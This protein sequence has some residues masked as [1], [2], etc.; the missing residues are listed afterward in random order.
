MLKRVFMI[1]V[2]I[3]FALCSICTF[4]SCKAETKNDLSGKTIGF[5]QY[6]TRSSFYNI[7]QQTIQ[8]ECD[9]NDIRLIV[10]DSD[11]SISEQISNISYFIDI[12]VDAIIINPVDNNALSGIIGKAREEGIFVIIVDNILD[13]SIEVDVSIMADNY[14]N[15]MLAGAWLAE[16]MGNEKIK[17]LY[18]S[19][20][21]DSIVSE[22][23]RSGLINGMSEYWLDNAERVDIEIT[24]RKQSDWTA[25]GTYTA[26]T[27][28]DK[29]YLDYNCIVSEAQI[30]ALT[31][32][33][34]LKHN[35]Q[36]ERVRYI[37]CAVCDAFSADAVEL[38]TSGKM[39]SGYQ[40]P[41]LFGKEAVN[42]AVK[43]WRNEPIEDVIKQPTILIE[44]DNFYKYF[45]ENG[46]H[47]NL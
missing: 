28:I 22:T 37:A 1:S 43:H 6:H 46:N 23:R 11:L 24:A 39:A 44:K 19:G 35:D 9:V 13:P 47:K 15:G 7:I 16:K 2:L 8:S 42:A 4:L 27:G 33:M 25:S 5:S 14:G 40:S 12:K 38:I 18:F 41:Y 34:V 32:M 31:A 21:E 26:M 30:V 45:D 36:D 17:A 20:I 10:K 29:E 3:I